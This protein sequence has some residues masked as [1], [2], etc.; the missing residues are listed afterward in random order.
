MGFLSQAM[1]GMGVSLKG[2]AHTAVHQEAATHAA[3]TV[4]Q[5][6]QP[7]T[8]QAILPGAKAT[9]FAKAEQGVPYSWGGG[10]PTGPSKGVAQGANTV[11]FDCSGLMKYAYAKAGITIPRDTYSQI[12]TLHPV[13][14]GMKAWKPGDLIYPEAGHVGMYIGNGQIVQAPQTGQNVEV[15]PVNG[16]GGWYS[17]YAV[18]RP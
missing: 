6:A 1:A 8:Q 15:S 18:R 11:G 4:G 12:A 17:P 13:D 16:P 3:Q 14:G 7:P 5:P 9:T 2:G 10:T